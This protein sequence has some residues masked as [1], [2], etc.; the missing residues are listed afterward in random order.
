M[1]NRKVVATTQPVEVKLLRDD[2]NLATTRPN[3][4][5]IID[6][7]KASLE[8]LQLKVNAI[9][10]KFNESNLMNERLMLL[11]ARLD[12]NIETIVKNNAFI[13]EKLMKVGPLIK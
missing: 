12:T 3:L 13:S 7:L 11:E 4:L 9:E 8:T 10:S 2:P 6:T 5:I 1:A